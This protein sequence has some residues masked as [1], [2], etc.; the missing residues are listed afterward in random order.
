MAIG[1]AATAPPGSG[2]LL[3]RAWFCL[4]C[5]EF[6]KAR[7]GEPPPRA[8]PTPGCRRPGGFGKYAETP[9]TRRR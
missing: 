2:E 7:E 3:G 6:I 8:C 1:N 5:N 9:A 4:Y